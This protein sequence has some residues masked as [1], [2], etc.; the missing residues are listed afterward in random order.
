MKHLWTL[1]PLLFGLE[2]TFISSAATAAQPGVFY[3]VEFGV[4][5]AGGTLPYSTKSI[6]SPSS[7][8]S[9]LCTY[10]CS[11]LWAWAYLLHTDII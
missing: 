5:E 4:L 11:L 6:K 2:L 1:H 10:L 3:L 7:S 8:M 9:F